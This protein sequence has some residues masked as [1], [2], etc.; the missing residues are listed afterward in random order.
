MVV[1]VTLMVLMSLLAVGLLSLATIQTRSSRNGEAQARAKAN[2]RL[3]LQIAIGKLQTYAGPDQRVTAGAEIVA[4]D[5]NPRWV[6]VW[7][8]NEDEELGTPLVDWSRRDSALVDAR[9]ARRVGSNDLFEGWLV[10]GEPGDDPDSASGPTIEL[11]GSGSVAR[12]EDE[13][14]VPLVTVTDSQGQ[15]GSYAF[16]CSDESMKVSLNVPLA[17]PGD[18]PQGVEPPER[19]GIEDLAGLDGYR[20]LRDEDLLKLTDYRQAELAG[21]G[22][23]AA[24][25]ENFHSAGNRASAVLADTL[26]GGLKRDL[27]V[28]I[29]DGEVE[30]LGDNLPALTENSPLLQGEKRK[31]QGPKLGVLRSFAKLAE[32][33]SS[34]DVEVSASP[35]LVA[36]DKFGEIPDLTRYTGQPV[37]PVIAQAE[38]YTRVCYVRGYITMHFYPRVVLWNPYNAPLKSQSYTLDFNQCINDSMTIE[39]RNGS[40]TDVG[41]R[42][43]NPRGNKGDRLS[44]TI[45]ATAFEPGEALVFSAKPGGGTLAGRATPL[46]QRDATGNNVLSAEIDPN[47]LTNFYLVLGNRLSGVSSRDLPL[48]ANHN[49]G[50]YYWVDM[51]DWWE[52]N[53]DNG[54][55][56]SLHLGSANSYGDRLDLPL[57]QLIDTDNWRRGYEGGFNNGRWRVGGVEPVYDYERTADFEP[58]TRGVY[59]IRYK[60]WVERNPYNYA[61]TGGQRFWGAAVTADYN[62]RAPFCHRS[63]FDAVTDN[64]EEHHW[65]M[66]GPYTCDRQQGLPFVSPERAA[67]GGSNGF[68][69]NPF[70]GGASSQPSTVYPIYDL[71]T[72]GERI[73]SLGRFQNAQLTPFIW[74]TSFPIGNSWVPPNL[75]RREQSTDS[76]RVMDTAWDDYVPHLPEWM[77]QGRDEDEEVIYDL[78]YEANHELW[79]RYFLSGATA[80]EKRRFSVNP[81]ASPLPN[82]R[83]VPIAGSTAE[84]ERLDNFYQAASEMLLAGAFNVNTTD[85]DAW[86]ALFASLK[87]REGSGAS[88]PRFQDPEDD[89]HDPTDPYNP[90]AWSGFRSLSDE[91]LDSLATSLVN[92][93]KR[94]GPFIS[95]SDFVNRRL[96]RDRGRGSEH[97]L[98]GPLQQAIEDAGINEGLEGGD[99]AMLS[100]G[101]GNASYEPG[102]KSDE[103]APQ[104]HLRSSKAVGMPTYLQQGDLLQPLG[105]MLVARG[106]TFVVR[107]YG[108]AR[109]EDGSKVVARAWCEAEVQRL[110]GYVVS[111]DPAEEPPFDADGQPNSQISEASR[112][113]GRRFEIVS[114][115]WLNSTEI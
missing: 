45:E 18:D 76:S 66:W 75:T 11:V 58:W 96:A 43:Y 17:E 59:G 21:I 30:S 81:S 9:Q 103:W 13:V 107:A 35:N 94:R 42:A 1:T 8:S 46:V 6:G 99:V 37:H 49:R 70:F 64:G 90:K 85:V 36:G 53:P 7:R 4:S 47:Q 28:F 14:S 50:S 89:E 73:V 100:T 67:H 33:G 20:G 93:V 115:R 55:K 78:A 5:N 74:H 106:D 111:T 97:G 23:A 87:D 79:D 12:A 29:E 80:D 60:W 31:V 41:G 105:S 44:F 16:W 95:V 19:Y 92:Q 108:D 48:Y 91:Q 102:S 113:F 68:R 86:R 82:S 112:R 110:P 26:R 98:M 52:R 71:P 77:K 2:A 3:A 69:G 25:R 57:L 63:P 88:F 62:V 83:L 27:T 24:L 38:I 10:S 104:E 56:I 32:R 51:M 61:G 101:Y 34:G 39:K 15:P 65:Y 54:L 109:S 84:A 72:D 22:D 114:F 40:T